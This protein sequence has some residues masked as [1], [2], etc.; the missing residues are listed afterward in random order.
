MTKTYDIETPE[1]IETPEPKVMTRTER[2][3]AYVEELHKMAEFFD[4]HPDLIPDHDFGGV[5]FSRSVDSA[6][7]LA[8]LLRS[9]GPCEKIVS[10]YFAGGTVTFGPHKIIVQTSKE[11]TCK[12]V[13]TGEV[14][15]RTVTGDPAATIPEGARN[16]RTVTQVVYDF[17]EP[18]TEWDCGSLLNPDTSND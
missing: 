13:P 8:A 16:V 17:D 18:V 15:A 6:E 14:K 3:D 10:G 9:L 12:K 4:A 5:T 7:A 11:N 1:E 2:R